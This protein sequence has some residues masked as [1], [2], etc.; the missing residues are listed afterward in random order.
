VV[1][2]VRELLARQSEGMDQGGPPWVVW[3]GGDAPALARAVDW[4]GARVVPDLVLHGLAAVA[5][6]GGDDS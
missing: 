3:T 2:A 1:G 6:R 5:F 4:P